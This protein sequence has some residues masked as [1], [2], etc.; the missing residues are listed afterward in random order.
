VLGT[1]G[2]FSNSELGIQADDQ[3][4]PKA[5]VAWTNAHGGIN[6]HPVKLIEMD[7]A[8]DTARG[9][10]AAQTMVGDHVLAVVG[11]SSVGPEVA[12]A[13]KLAQAN[14]P[15][16]GGDDYD[17]I[18]EQNPD[19]FPTMAT[20]SVK[21]YADDYAAKFAGAKSVVASY[22]REVAACLQDVQAQKVAAPALG[23]KYTIGPTASFVAPNY[24]AQCVVM[25]GSKADAYY[26][27]SAVQG[28]E[29]MASD[30]QRQGL[31]GLWILPQP[32]DTQLKAPGIAKQA[33]GQDLQLSYFADLPATQPFRQAMAQYA[34]GVKLQIDS[35][36]IWA[37]FDVTKKALEGV[38]NEPLTPQTVKDGLYT[39]NGF[40]DNGIVPP[41]TY[42]K[43][44]PTVVRCFEVWG[45]SNGKFTLPQGDKFTCA[46]NSV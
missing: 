14:I 44:K 21:G 27:S 18:W 26:F 5:W 22:C 34:P 13:P 25:G 20:V 9:V 38:P 29:H 17:T 31:T 12:Y 7:D 35:L 19:L 32:D 2:N 40:T 39:L 3:A 43:N 8:G 1:I 15:M 10:A 46:P 4:T 30:C 23:I 37:A 11:N 24:T 28:I 36:R 33:I 6:G 45:I 42:V 41:L 16:V